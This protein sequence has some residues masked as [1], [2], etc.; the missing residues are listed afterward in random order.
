MS[1]ILLVVETSFY[2]YMYLQLSLVVTIFITV[3]ILEDLI[4]PT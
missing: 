4:Y 3:L 1:L 2:C